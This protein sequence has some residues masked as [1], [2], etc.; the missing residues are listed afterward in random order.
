VGPLIFNIYINELCDTINHS[1]SV[2]PADDHEVY[3][4]VKVQCDC[5]LLQ[6]DIC[7]VH[8]W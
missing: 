6:S 8:D 3:G 4:G 2:P 1:T 7:C 5:L